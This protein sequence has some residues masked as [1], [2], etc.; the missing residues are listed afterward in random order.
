MAFFGKKKGWSKKKAPGNRKRYSDTQKFM[1]HSHKDSHYSR[2]F[3]RG[4]TH[5]YS[6]FN[7]SGIEAEMVSNRG[8]RDRLYWADMYGVRNG[9]AAAVRFKKKYGLLPYGYMQLN[10]KLPE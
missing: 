9:S 7:L 8:C 6:D 4:F 10:G 1:Y 5:P 2:G 3:V